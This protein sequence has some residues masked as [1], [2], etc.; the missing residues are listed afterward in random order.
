MIASY[1]IAEDHW[2][3]DQAYNEMRTFHF[4]RHLLLMGHYVKFFPANFA[5]SPAF[6]S[7][8]NELSNS[9]GYGR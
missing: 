4:H 9:N 1:R 7:L 8:R 3:A 6:Q 2:T 5:L